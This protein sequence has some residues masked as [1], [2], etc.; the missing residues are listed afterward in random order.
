[1][2]LESVSRSYSP[3]P[4]HFHTPP[5][6]IFFH[7]RFNSGQCLLSHASGKK[8]APAALACITAALYAKPGKQYFLCNENKPR[9]DLLLATIL[10]VR[11]SPNDAAPSFWPRSSNGKTCP[12]ARKAIQRSLGIPL[13]W[14]SKQAPVALA[15]PGPPHT[16]P[17]SRLPSWLCPCPPPPLSRP[18]APPLRNLASSAFHSLLPFGLRFLL[19]ARTEWLLIVVIRWSPRFRWRSATASG[20]GASRSLTPE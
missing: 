9:I 12:K 5:R 1:M 4:M 16:P 3:H 11:S 18:F 7:Q 15:A 17:P 19:A 10:D 13:E 6:I 8:H 14:F 2:H 20:G